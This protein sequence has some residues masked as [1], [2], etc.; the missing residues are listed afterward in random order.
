MRRKQFRMFMQW[1]NEIARWR[2]CSEYSSYCNICG[3]TKAHVYELVK[4]PILN[5]SDP[6]TGISTPT[7]NFDFFSITILSL[8]LWNNDEKRR[9]TQNRPKISFFQLP[10]S[11][12]FVHE[13]GICDV[14]VDSCLWVLL[15]HF[16]VINMITRWP[17]DLS[18]CYLISN[19]VTTVCQD[20]NRTHCC[21]AVGRVGLFESWIFRQRYFEY[22]MQAKQTSTYY[23]R[24]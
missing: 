10:V 4:T 9:S 15:G 20:N 11:V 23:F 22:I 13:N 19:H 3:I 24:K 8:S 16:I 6:K 7:L 14:Y 12:W 17:T 5:S 2:E 21:V 18:H 1:R